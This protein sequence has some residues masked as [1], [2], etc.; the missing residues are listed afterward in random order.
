MLEISAGEGG[1]EAMDSEAGQSLKRPLV[2]SRASVAAV[3]DDCEVAIIEKPPDFPQPARK[4]GRTVYNVGSVNDE[5]CILDFDPEKIVAVS[6][7][8]E[9]ESEDLT[10]TAERGHVACRDYPHSRHCCVSFP[11]NSTPHEKHCALCH[12]YVCDKP[13]PCLTWGQ[14][15]SM[16][17]HCHASDKEEKWK[18]LR[19]SYKLNKTQMISPPIVDDVIPVLS[20]GRST[21][22]VGGCNQEGAEAVTYIP[23]NICQNA[24]S[25]SRP[26]SLTDPVFSEWPFYSAAL[27]SHLTGQSRGILAS[28]MSSIDR[29]GRNNSIGRKAV[30]STFPISSHGG[31][32]QFRSCSSIEHLNT[33]FHNAITGHSTSIHASSRRSGFS[34]SNHNLA[35]ET[36]PASMYSSC[37]CM[38]GHSG[39]IS[40][41]GSIQTNSMTP[42]VQP[43]GYNPVGRR[44]IASASLNINL[45]AAVQSGHQ[46]STND[47]NPIFETSPLSTFGLHGYLPSHNANIG[48]SGSMH[49]ISMCSPDQTGR[50]NQ[51]HIEPITSVQSNIGHVS[52]HQSMPCSSKNNVNP[53]FQPGMVSTFGLQAHFPGQIESIGQSRTKLASPMNSTGQV[54]SSKQVGPTASVSMDISQ[55]Y[56]HQIK[57]SPFTNDLNPASWTQPLSEF[58]FSSHLLLHNAKIGQSQSMF[59]D[60]MISTCQVGR[61]DQ[62]STGTVACIPCYVSHSCGDQFRPSSFTNNLNH[63][64]QTEP[65]NQLRS[66]SF[67]NNLKSNP[68]TQPANQFRQSL[69]TNN[70]QLNP[71]SQTQSPFTFGL[72]S[73]LHGWT[74]IRIASSTSSMDQVGTSHDASTDADAMVS[75]Y[76]E[77]SSVHPVGSIQEESCSSTENPYCACYTNLVSSISMPNHLPGQILNMHV[78]FTPRDIPHFYGTG[79]SIMATRYHGSKISSLESNQM[80]TAEPLNMLSPN[81]KDQNTL[82]TSLATQKVNQSADE[83]DSIDVLSRNATSIRNVTSEDELN[84]AQEVLPGSDFDDNLYIYDT[85]FTDAFEN[86]LDPWS[87]SEVQP[88]IQASSSEQLLSLCDSSTHVPQV[89]SNIQIPGC[90]STIPT[91]SN[92]VQF[93]AV[94]QMR[95]TSPV[96]N[97]A[98]D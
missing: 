66:S 52:G 20:S 34:T 84:W 90:V 87:Y 37:S 33:G 50:S 74:E 85:F 44:V 70:L 73:H 8:I 9:N 68:P 81:K 2:S 36:G 29:A 47:L 11:F 35:P 1:G 92:S 5:C 60:T 42:T 18:K 53:A 19:H 48:K 39:R 77:S 82:E 32:H 91:L 38:P 54:G 22:L 56:A 3:H 69:C 21:F 23:S 31:V 65:T 25:Q 97:T 30:T 93:P 94:E 80:E 79:P 72:S 16:T 67:T 95:V 6:E 63:P 49:G 10:V 43:G 28:S 71:P 41:S 46:T 4:R 59:A 58:D 24:A 51:V 75:L 83:G 45:G 55:G 62:V 89:A 98:T 13:A 12:C 88:M 27:S 78:G 26:T 57:P 40:Q 17:D 96:L 64:P 14:G 86:C 76:N 7:T 15:K 61:S